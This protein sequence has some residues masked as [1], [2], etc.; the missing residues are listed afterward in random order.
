M[1]GVL[2]ALASSANDG[3]KKGTRIVP[4]EFAQAF[5]VLGQLFGGFTDPDTNQKMPSCSLSIFCEGGRLKWCLIPK[6]G[7]KVCFGTLHDWDNP[8]ES[9][10]AALSKGEC[11]WKPTNRK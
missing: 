6:D 11:E 5:P 3:E 9:L 7:P 4:V 1:N 10:Q 2:Q 8:W